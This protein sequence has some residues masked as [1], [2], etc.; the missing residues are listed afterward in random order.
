M[1]VT[2]RTVQA[3]RAQ[4]WAVL[5]DG[6]SYGDWVV[7]T[8]SIRAVDPEFPAVGSALHY[9]IGRGRLSK[10]GHTEVLACDPGRSLE[11]EAHGWPAGTVYIGIHLYDEG[12]RTRV[13]QEEHPRRGLAARL[14]N[15][16]WDLLIDLRNR[17]GLRRLA[18]LAEEG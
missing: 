3:D 17:E 11:L 12:G 15:P 16:L 7:G 14:H 4:V 13:R 9:R 6:T 18:R 1:A 2:E 8:T 10:D 5:A